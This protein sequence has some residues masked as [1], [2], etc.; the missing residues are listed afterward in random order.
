MSRGTPVVVKRGDDDL[1][2][3]VLI[4]ITVRN[5]GGRAI[6]IS[7]VLVETL[8]NDSLQAYEIVPSALPQT[9]DPE[10]SVVVT[11]QKEFLDDSHVVTFLG[12]LDALG[13]RHAVEV[14]MAR[15]LIEASWALPTR[16]ATYR[17]RDDPNKEVRAFQTKDRFSMSRRPVA[18]M[19]SR[20]ATRSEGTINHESN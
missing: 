19:P 20:I 15:N 10:G 16:V 18:K 7:S 17:R 3:Q 6:Q 4:S 9:I 8:A 11:I 12:V 14:M 2:E 5:R 13:R 1:L